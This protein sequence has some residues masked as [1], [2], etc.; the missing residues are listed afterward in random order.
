M[1]RLVLEIETVDCEKLVRVKR[2]THREAK[3]GD[4]DKLTFLS[5][6]SSEGGAQND[7]EAL[8]RPQTIPGR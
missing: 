7:N 3:F 4:G 6:K 2:Q 1:K 8:D 5:S